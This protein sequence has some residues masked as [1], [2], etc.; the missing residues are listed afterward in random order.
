MR[1]DV[2]LLPGFGGAPSQPVLVRLEKRLAALGFSCRR[3]APRRGKLTPALTLETTWLRG[4]M[5]EVDGPHVLIGRSFGGRVCVRAATA[6]VA[7][8]VLLGFPVR[9][10]NK[11]RPLDEQALVAVR[12]PTLV[13]QGDDD[14]LGPLSVIKRLAKKNR[15]ITVQVV[16][17]AGHSFGAREASALDGAAAWL[18]ETA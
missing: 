2:I 10:P 1:S 14:E 15:L 16:K 4:V 11:P 12:C 13:V 6:E 5:E 8:C 17:G 9:P 18:D 7:A 3:R